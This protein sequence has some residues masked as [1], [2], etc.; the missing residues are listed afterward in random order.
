MLCVSFYKQDF[1]LF[2]SIGINRI[3]LKTIIKCNVS[4]PLKL[5]CKKRELRAATMQYL[6][7]P[8]SQQTTGPRRSV[9]MGQQSGVF[10]DEIGL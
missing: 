9:Q 2:S 1:L 10:I 7:H 6:C 4:W 3:F 5:R 8:G